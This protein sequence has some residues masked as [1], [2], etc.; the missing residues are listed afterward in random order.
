MAAVVVLCMALLFAADASAQQATAKIVGT[1]T[2]PQGAVL[3]ASKLRSRIPRPTFLPKRSQTRAA[4][5]RS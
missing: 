5:S 3:R 1:I 2:D 4:F